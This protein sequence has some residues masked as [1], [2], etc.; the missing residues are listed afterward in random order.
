MISVSFFEF[1]SKVYGTNIM[2]S[3][4]KRLNYSESGARQLLAKPLSNFNPDKFIKKIKS[5]NPLL[6]D[7][8]Y[9]DWQ[10]L[11]EEFKNGVSSPKEYCK[12]IINLHEQ[13]A[14]DEATIPLFTIGLISYS[15]ALLSKFIRVGPSRSSA[16]DLFAHFPHSLFSEAAFKSLEPQNHCQANLYG[17]E[18]VILI[19][20]ALDLDLELIDH[21]REK[22][23][24]L[25]SVN[26]YLKSGVKP[27]QNWIS[28]L[29]LEHNLKSKE[30]LYRLMS[31]KSGEDTDNIRG[32]LKDWEKGTK[33][34]AKKIND[35]F[36]ELYPE[37]TPDEYIT[38]QIKYV[39]V[40]VN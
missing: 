16:K 34:T 32:R 38:F 35:L 36:I 21:K 40:V 27:I 17:I 4:M 2:V 8:S 10:S 19:I 12:K 31:K 13:A 20:A 37:S 33:P 24:G 25:N 5:K 26:S 3:I 18:C 30:A 7:I 29:H 11:L 22:M 23:F 15:E 9:D 14:P 39:I 6:E 28:N 1:L